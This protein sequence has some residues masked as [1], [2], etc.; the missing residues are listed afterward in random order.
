MDLRFGRDIH[1]VMRYHSTV[2]DGVT[3]R[4]DRCD[5]SANIPQNKSL[6][7]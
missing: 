6:Y 7:L 5:P 3:R 4:A 2:F 1:G